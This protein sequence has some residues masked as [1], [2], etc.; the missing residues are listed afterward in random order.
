MQRSALHFADYN[1]RKISPEGRKAL[2]K[3]I[4]QF[5]VVGGIVVNKNGH[6]IVGGH[7]KV[8]ILDEI[9]KGKD[10]TLRVEMIDVDK[11]T[12]KALNVALNNP[13][14]GGEWDYDKLAELVPDIDWQSAGLTEAD[15]SFIGVDY[16]F[17]TESI[18]EMASELED[19][20]ETSKPLK[21][22]KPKSTVEELKSIKQQVKADA[23]KKAET[24]NSYVVLS[25]DNDTNKSNFLQ[26]FGYSPAQQYIKGEDFDEKCDVVYE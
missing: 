7:Q 3:S 20:H 11:P 9:A 14:V 13:N 6:T 23:Q 18:D 5:G 2:K 12:E 26:R 4:K 21:E 1:P 22:P 24:M 17:Q 15:L 8:S 19:L 16:L 10:Y 25:F